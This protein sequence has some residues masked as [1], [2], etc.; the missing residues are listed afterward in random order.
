MVEIIVAVL[1]VVAFFW[2][3][4]FIMFLINDEYVPKEKEIELPKIY[5][6]D[7]CGKDLKLSEQEYDS[8][9]VG[10]EPCQ[11]CLDLIVSETIED[12]K[13]AMQRKIEEI[14]ILDL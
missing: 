13:E 2:T 4:S 5:A 8:G 3:C 10:L 11:S 7:V 1:L 14:N 9:F 12:M 6:C